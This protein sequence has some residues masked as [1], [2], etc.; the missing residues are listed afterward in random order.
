[1]IIGYVFYEMLL[2]LFI[3]LMVKWFVVIVFFGFELQDEKICY[4]MVDNVL[5]EWLFDFD[6][7]VVKNILKFIFLLGILGWYLDQIEVFYV[8]VGYFWLLVFNVLVIV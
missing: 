3:G 6:G 2:E 7:L 5:V 8:D 1:M 4:Q